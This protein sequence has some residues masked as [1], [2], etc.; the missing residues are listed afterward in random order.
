[1]L[2]PLR[3]MI[4]TNTQKRLKLRK[5]LRGRYLVNTKNPYVKTI[6]LNAVKSVL[7]SVS[8]QFLSISYP[9]YFKLKF[10]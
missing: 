8:Q 3:I 7:L 1:M 5:Y 10:P 2:N 6:D 4:K 9:A